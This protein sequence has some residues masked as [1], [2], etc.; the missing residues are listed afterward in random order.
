M[1]VRSTAQKA[2]SVFVETNTSDAF[3]FGGMHITENVDWFGKG[4]NSGS[5]PRAP[6][7]K[8]SGGFLLVEFPMGALVFFL[9]S[10]ILTP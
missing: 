10:L 2:F 7:Q 9:K 4:S 8:K 5:N 6:P 1:T 3:R